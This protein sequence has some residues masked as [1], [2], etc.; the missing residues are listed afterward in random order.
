MTEKS[1]H[2]AG[3]SVPVPQTQPVPVEP[4]PCPEC[5]SSPEHITGITIP[6]VETVPTENDGR[7]VFAES[8]QNKAAFASEGS[9]Q[10][11]QT[12]SLSN[13]RP[14]ELPGIVQQRAEPT[15]KIYRFDEKPDACPE[16]DGHCFVSA[17]GGAAMNLTCYHCFLA[18]EIER[19]EAAVSK[20]S[21]PTNPHGWR[22][23]CCCC[24]CPPKDKVCSFNCA[25]HDAAPS[26]DAPRFADGL[27]SKH[28]DYDARY[29]RCP[30]CEEEIGRGGSEDAPQ[31]QE[32]WR[33]LP[34]GS[35]FFCDSPNCTDRYSVQGRTSSGCTLVCSTP[36]HHERAKRDMQEIAES[37]NA[38]IRASEDAP[39]TPHAHTRNCWDDGGTVLTC[40]YGAD[41]K[42]RA[43][44]ASAQFTVEEAAMQ[45]IRY[46]LQQAYELFG[47]GHGARLEGCLACEWKRRVEHSGLGQ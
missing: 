36:Y 39:A 17:G 31:A 46:L 43:I 33:D 34:P 37:H 23:T 15:R 2:S 9:T 20:E 5:A 42:T 18:E 32:S 28:G 11:I 10:I 19:L 47:E 3:A 22:L 16:C 14:S 12:P 25:C 41:P 44:E 30:K 8:E 40:P 6:A 29:L 27:C 35:W 26:E 7:R 24:G 4:Q 21:A 45:E 38:R 1:R 13:E